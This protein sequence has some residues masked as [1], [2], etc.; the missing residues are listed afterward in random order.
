MGREESYS[1]ILPLINEDTTVWS[2][3]F[4]IH[5]NCVNIHQNAELLY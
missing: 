4:L 2:V 1:K 3:P 5:C